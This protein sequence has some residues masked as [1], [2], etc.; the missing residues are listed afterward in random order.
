VTRNRVLAGAVIAVVV[1]ATALVVGLIASNRGGSETSTG[2]AEGARG[3]DAR[4]V[5]LTGPVLFG[6]TV[7]AVVEV[8]LDR[9]R[10]DPDSVRVK[11]DFSPWKP[12]AGPNYVRHDGPTTT[13]LATTFRLRCLVAACVSS[14]D[15]A[16]QT[17]LPARVT[18]ATRATAGTSSTKSS[19]KVKWPPL[20]VAARFP[21]KG[22]QSASANAFPWRI[23]LLSLP[24]VTYRLAPGLLFALLLAGGIVL[25]LAGGWFVHLA[26]PRRA[27]PLAL[28][29]DERPEPAPV[30][31][32][33]Q[34]A[35]TLLENSAS[36]D[37]AADRRR[38]LELVAAGLVERGD[39]QLA[40]AA[41][42][43]AWSEHV[44]SVEE[45][46]GFVAHARSTFGERSHQPAEEAPAEEPHEPGE[47]PHED[48]A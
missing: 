42:T 38:A 41:R 10:V 40:R 24:A 20:V 26:L 47:E 13:Y 29:A 11:T 35:F 5:L 31:T 19:L 44:P 23:D 27:V 17:F 36:V 48:L 15:V 8:T 14:N 7:T 28:E 39:V 43:L 21:P 4:A 12:V 34:Y 33:L 9:N 1:V 45:T 46:S 22:A 30:L 6:D 3:I 16:S 18:Y 2:A 32:A 25:A 37:G